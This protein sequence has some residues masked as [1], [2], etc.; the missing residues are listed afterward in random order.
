MAGHRS[1]VHGLVEVDVT[2]PGERIRTLKT[3][4]GTKL[5][6]TAYIVSC[7]AATLADQPHVQR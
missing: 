3:E 1:N 2:D 4:T 7:L 5:S 6:F